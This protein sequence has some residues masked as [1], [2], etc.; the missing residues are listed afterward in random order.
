MDIEL[1]RIDTGE[2]EMVTVPDTI[3]LTK[4]AQ[5]GDT[6][7]VGRWR[8]MPNDMLQ[9]WA[10]RNGY[11]VP[12]V[13]QES[14]LVTDP[15]MY[16]TTVMSK[17][18]WPG[19]EE[20]T[21]K[22]KRHRRISKK[23]FIGSVKQHQRKIPDLEF[24]VQDGTWRGN[25]LKGT[26]DREY[27]RLMEK[28]EGLAE[29]LKKDKIKVTIVDAESGKDYSMEDGGGLY[30]YHGKIIVSTVRDRLAPM[31]H[32]IGSGA[33]L[34]DTTFEGAFRHE[35][36]HHISWLTRV[37]DSA[38]MR[39]VSHHMKLDGLDDTKGT[40]RR[41]WLKDNISEY[42]SVNYNEAFSE[43]FAAYT[44]KNYGTKGKLPSE[45]EKVIKS[46]VHAKK[47]KEAIRVSAAMRVLAEKMVR[48]KAHKRRDSKTG[49]IEDVD[50]F[51][52]DTKDKLQ[53]G[54]KQYDPDNTTPIQTKITLSKTQIG[55]IGE[56][57]AI[58][59]KGGVPLGNVLGQTRNNLAYDVIN[60][61]TKTLYEIK[62]GAISNARDVQKWRLTKGEPSQAEKLFLNRAT[63]SAKLMYNRGKEGKIIARKMA[64]QK[65]VERLTG[66]KY[67][68]KTLTFIINPDTR[69]A[70]SYEFEGL[71]PTIRWYSDLARKGYKRSVKY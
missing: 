66:H 62:A 26:L 60:T 44:H 2:Q 71:H 55:K 46:I 14:I 15:K 29:L 52:R 57:L 59:L 38:F 22:V 24:D 56:Q 37:D 53:S 42:G 51:V 43:A 20:A 13:V 41:Q 70:D 5:K 48:V 30:D 36:G 23:G 28:Y 4:G 61:K 3:V 40:Q 25:S 65:E 58:K 49:K 6:Y 17:D 68:T 27:K 50:A 31:R 34:T 1:T 21:T 19:L 16:P 69:T 9:S 67:K 12:E 18:E 45:I 39:A 64:L 10:Y 63:V 7:V 35:I 54:E 33:Y 32:Q 47:L 11:E 8:P